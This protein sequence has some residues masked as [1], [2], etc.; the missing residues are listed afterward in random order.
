MT[1]I[2]TYISA[3]GFFLAPLEAVVASTERHGTVCAAA[4]ANRVSPFY[5]SEDAA[6]AAAAE[7]QREYEEASA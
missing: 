3:Q 4:L 6:H 5:E 1:T 2:T 7:K